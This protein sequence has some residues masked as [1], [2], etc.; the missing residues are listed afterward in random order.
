MSLLKSIPL[1]VTLIAISIVPF[2]AG[3]AR[4]LQVA[5]VDIQL[6][7][8]PS[9]STWLLAVFVAHIVA[10]F[11]F[12]GLGAFQFTTHANP[13]TLGR[14]RAAGRVAATAAVIAGG[15]AIWLTLFF[16]HAP[17]DGP[18]LNIIRVFAGAGIVT[19]VAM[20]YRAIRAHRLGHH[21][22]WMMRAY[23][24]CAATG[25]QSFVVII[26]SLIDENPA[27]ISRAIAFGGSWL[28]SLVFVE[29]RTSRKPLE[30]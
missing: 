27:G 3:T 30:R 19:C 7:A 16:P 8:H 10:A 9:V 24:L 1:P 29:I 25:V 18:V 22:K 4:L 17:H 28:A 12:L 13:Q 6:T 2:A 23:A 11:L 20:G 14:H 15:A 5:A 26:W 21:R